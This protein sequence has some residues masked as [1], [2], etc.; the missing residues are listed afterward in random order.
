MNSPLKS[1]TSFNCFGATWCS[2]P[3][4]D[5]DEFTLIQSDFG[6]VGD[7]AVECSTPFGDIDEFT[8]TLE[9]FALELGI[10]EVLNAFRR[11]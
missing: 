5:I 11:H 6:T 10:D 4:G 8:R 3:F 2:T 9:D 7:S 1:R